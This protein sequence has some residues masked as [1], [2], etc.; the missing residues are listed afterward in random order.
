MFAFGRKRATI[1][2]CEKEKRWRLLASQTGVI[3]LSTLLL[4]PSSYL[5]SVLLWLGGIVREENEETAFMAVFSFYG[6][7]HRKR[8]WKPFMVHLRFPLFH[9]LICLE[10]LL[11]EKTLDTDKHMTN[12]SCLHVGLS[13]IN[14]WCASNNTKPTNN[15]LIDTAFTHHTLHSN[16]SYLMYEGD[17]SI[18]QLDNHRTTV[19][20]NDKGSVYAKYRKNRS[21]SY[22]VLKFSHADSVDFTSPHF[23]STMQHHEGEWIFNVV[24]RDLKKKKKS[25]NLKQHLLS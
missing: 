21:L 2:I 3:L 25:L 11:R 12:I 17:K 15:I 7:P 10:Q 5:I 24:L 13:D 1:S 20:C 8:Y 9:P 14:Q 6:L 18:K 22:K 4:F 16:S 19:Y 23:D